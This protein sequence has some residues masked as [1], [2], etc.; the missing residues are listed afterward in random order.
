MLEQVLEALP[1]GN[2]IRVRI[3]DHDAVLTVDRIWQN[4]Y[5]A[6]INHRKNGWLYALPVYDGDSIPALKTAILDYFEQ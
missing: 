4:H 3:A 2:A 5:K 1:D 6:R